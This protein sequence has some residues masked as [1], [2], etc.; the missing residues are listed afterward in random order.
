MKVTFMMKL[1]VS[2]VDELSAKDFQIAYTDVIE[3]KINALTF[4]KDGYEF[5]I[6]VF[7]ERKDRVEYLKVI[8][9]VDK[10]IWCITGVQLS[11]LRFSNS[12]KALW[13]LLYSNSRIIDNYFSNKAGDLEDIPS[14]YSMMDYLHSCGTL[15]D[16]SYDMLIEITNILSSSIEG[17]ISDAKLL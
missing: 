5:K 4:H 15:Q 13:I 12:P 1:A 17:Q 7:T 11:P 10:Q 14:L 16:K 3:N 8:G 9:D 2:I 6:A